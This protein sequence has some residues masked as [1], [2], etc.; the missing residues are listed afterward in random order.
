MTRSPLVPTILILCCFAPPAQAQLLESISDA[1]DSVQA[2]VTDVQNKVN[3]IRTDVT[4]IKTNVVESAQELAAGLATLGQDVR[5]EISEALEEITDG[6]DELKADRA[7]FR[8]NAGG[9]K[10]DLGGMLSNLETLATEISGFTGLPVTFEF[11]KER[12]VVDHLP[13]RALGPLY[14]ALA[15]EDGGAFSAFVGGLGE[16]AASL[17]RLR[18]ADTC[19]E[20]LAHPADILATVSG[21]RKSGIGMKL[22]AKGL[23]AAGATGI[24]GKPVQVAGFAGVLIENNR[25][26]KWGERL[27]GLS[28]VVLQVASSKENLLRY[29]TIVNG[30]DQIK[31]IL[32]GLN[33]D[34][35]FLDSPVSS[36]ASQGSVDALAGSVNLTL[37]AVGQMGGDHSL[38]LRVQIE[39]ALAEKEKRLALF[40][41]PGSHQGLLDLVREITEDTV[42][43][44]QLLQGPIQK[45]WDLLEAADRAMALADFERAYHLY[46]EAYRAAAR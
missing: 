6:I 2:K 13:D 41:R 34:L 24:S 36:R 25:K 33:L 37:E 8:A 44:Q 26:K 29:C 31:A 1:I 20:M 39:E 42:V 4:N 9:F 45:A 12:A 3:G 10:K 40:S 22:V 46:S 15:G 19:P 43:Q 11:N 14:A 23:I 21:V 18:E 17:G 27:D 28:A 7:A 16:A 30:T 5:E 32:S 38:L 35:T